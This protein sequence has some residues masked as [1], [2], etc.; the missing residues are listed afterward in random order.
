MTDV[1]DPAQVKTA[2]TLTLA[3]KVAKVTLLGAGIEVKSIGTTGYVRLSDF[4]DGAGLGG[5]EL[6]E[7]VKGQWIKVSEQDVN[8]ATGGDRKESAEAFTLPDRDKVDRLTA[9]ASKSKLV[10]FK[11]LGDD[12]IDGQPAYHYGYAI[13]KKQL[14]AFIPEAGQIVNGKPLSAA[15]VKET[16]DVFDSIDFK[17][18]E[19]WIG[20]KDKLPHKVTLGI[21][22]NSE[23]F[24]DIILSLTMSD[25]DRPVK[26]EAPQD[27]KT[28]EQLEKELYGDGVTVEERDSDGDGHSD[29]EE[30]RNG[31]DPYGPGRARASAR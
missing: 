22:S 11:K 5:G 21:K 12:S 28:I 24:T 14:E 4:T 8:E 18:G 19:I 15:E 17:E 20:K 3:G 9:A 16:A 6:L 1:T 31:F 27:A 26:I 2:A 25:F 30:V 10:T 7:P 13:D 29:E 23:A